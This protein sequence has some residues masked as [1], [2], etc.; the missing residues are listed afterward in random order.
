M[1]ISRWLVTKSTRKKCVT[2]KY[3]YFFKI[4]KSLE[5]CVTTH[6]YRRKYCNPNIEL[7]IRWAYLSLISW[8]ARIITVFK[9]KL[10]YNYNVYLLVYQHKS[11]KVIWRL[12][13]QIAHLNMKYCFYDRNKILRDGSVSD[14]LLTQYIVRGSISLYHL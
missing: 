5:F 12:M 6:K 11:C 2:T 9:S 7:K 14:L 13:D 10:N 8:C 1:C 3:I 4:L